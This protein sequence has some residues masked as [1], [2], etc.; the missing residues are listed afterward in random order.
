[1]SQ[2][3]P[4]AHSPRWAALLPWAWTSLAGAGIFVLLFWAH[5][6][7]A[8]D[9]AFIT[10]RYAQNL[11]QGLGFVYNPGE[12]V[13]GTTAPLYGLLLGG[14]GRLLPHVEIATLG[15]WISGLA[16]IGILW[17]TGPLLRSWGQPPAVGMVATLLLAVQ[18]H[19]VSFLGMETSLVILAMWLSGWAWA[20][21]QWPWIGLTSALLILTRQDGALW[22]LVLGLYHW[23]SRGRFPWR[24]AGATVL[25]CL[26]WFLYAWGQYGSPLPHSVLAKVGQTEA[27]PIRS[28][29]TIWQGFWIYLTRGSISPVYPFLSA[30]LLALGLLWVAVR[31]PRLAWM[32]LWGVLYLAIYQALHV[33]GFGWYF[34]PPLA[35]A[36][37]LTGVGMGHLWHGAFHGRDPRL[38]RAVRVL[39]VGLLLT[40]LGLRG[41]ILAGEFARFDRRHPQLHP[42]H[43]TGQWLAAHADPEATIASIEIGVI[44]YHVPNPILDTMGLVSPQMRPFLTGWSDTLV[45][46][47]TQFWPEYVVTLPRTAWE[48][49]E[50]LWW[51][52]AHYHHQADFDYVHIYRL[53]T[54]PDPPYV[55]AVDAALQPGLR[56]VQAR[57]QRQILPP[58]LPLDGI[59]DLQVDRP[60][61]PNLQIAVGWVSTETGL[62]TPRQVTWPFDAQ[63]IWPPEH[64]PVGHTIHLPLRV[65]IPADLPPGRYRLAVGLYDPAQGRPLG[66][67]A[68]IGD[69]QVLDGETSGN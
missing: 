63:G 7:A 65:Q 3:L 5:P 1:M 10:Y 62:A 55:V 4:P 50:P 25:L 27:M 20:R 69:F 43:P 36:A 67:E 24:E 21:G 22:V 49:V 19:M 2:T 39:L 66:D 34:L 41:Q 18:P 37:L 53:Q 16:W 11:R 51:F 9:D 44:G 32:V 8:V 28:I 30:G 56:L 17:T 68:L 23:Y 48:H 59:L 45:A 57:F 13:L 35:V 61:P 15:L 58:G 64:W 31:Q 33:V 26:P 47:V 29:R 54:R 12:A 52:Q 60:L 14:V 38:G 40:L 6:W 42:Y 46:A